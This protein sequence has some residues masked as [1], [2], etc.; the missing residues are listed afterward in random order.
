M[1]LWQLTACIAG[2][3]AANRPP[4]QTGPKPPT[5]EDHQDRLRRLKGRK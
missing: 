5:M 1:S 4:E 2:H 3:N